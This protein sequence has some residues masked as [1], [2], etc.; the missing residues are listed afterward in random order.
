V[1]IAIPIP[2]TANGTHLV[3]VKWGYHVALTKSS[4][5]ASHCPAPVINSY[6]YGSSYCS[7]DASASLTAYLYTQ[8]IT[9]GTSFYPSNYWSGVTNGSSQTTS[10]YCNGQSCTFQ[11]SSSNTYGGLSVHSFTWWVNATASKGDRV[12][13]VISVSAYANANAYGYPKAMA[14]AAFNLA[15][16]GNIGHVVWVQVS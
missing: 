11:N 2:I 16:L 15:T 6:G 13:V 14:A 10:E 5:G 3:K 1:T 12:I 4:K 9:N 8:D 7:L